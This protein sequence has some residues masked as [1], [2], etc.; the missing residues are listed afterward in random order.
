VH[1]VQID[2]V[3]VEAAQAVLDRL[4]HPLLRSPP[5][6][7]ELAHSI[8]E[9]GSE[10]HFVAPT[11]QSLADDLLGF[12]LRVDICRVDEVDA[13]VESMVDHPDACSM[14]LVTPGSEHHRTKTVFRDLETGTTERAKFHVGILACADAKA[15]K[16]V[17]GQ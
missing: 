11:L 17:K 6:V 7:R 5:L 1:L 13:A 12:T 10:H 4:M 9:L 14:V 16:R 15:P 2:V 3:R 8:P